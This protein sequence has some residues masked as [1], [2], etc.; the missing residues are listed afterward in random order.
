M[1]EKSKEAIQ[2]KDKE[3]KKSQSKYA[4]VINALKGKNKIMKKQ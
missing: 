1:M 2:E 4:E 3:I